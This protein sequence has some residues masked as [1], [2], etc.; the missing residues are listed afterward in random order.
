MAV[1]IGQASKDE[2]GQYR[3]GTAGDQTGQEV[4]IRTWYNRPWDTVLRWKNESVAKAFAEALK[5]ICNSPKV[6]YDQNQRT[7]LWSECEKINWQIT[8][9]SQISACECDCSSLMAVCARFCGLSVS[10][11]I[12][13]GNLAAAFKATGQVEILKDSMYTTKSDYL[14]VGDI[15]LNTQH[16]VAAVVS[17]PARTGGK[18]VAQYAATV[19]ASWLNVRTGPG[20]NYPI[21]THQGHQFGLPQGQIISIQAEDN[22]W[23]QL[24]NATGWVCLTYVAR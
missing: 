2:R 4:C 9:L 20:T 10:K 22:G 3:G 11:D 21:V 12:W 1:M 8:R 14:H 15:L 23:G 18:T 7:T 5:A 17:A 16:H 19:T 6:G 13:T 24:T